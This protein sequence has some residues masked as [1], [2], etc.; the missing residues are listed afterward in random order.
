MHTGD[1]NEAVQLTA[2]RVILIVLVLL[3]LAASASHPP[4][5]ETRYVYFLYPLAVVVALVTLA[6]GFRR[7][8][9]AASRHHGPALP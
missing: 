1:R 8:A 7:I 9:R 6:R 5:H 3:L 4:R 2:E